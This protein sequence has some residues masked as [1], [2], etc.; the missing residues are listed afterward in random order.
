[1]N[2]YI[3]KEFKTFAWHLGAM[4]LVGVI[5]IVLKPEFLQEI[6]LSE[7]T[8]VVMGLLANR[9]TKMLNK[10]GQ[11]ELWLKSWVTNE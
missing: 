5:A 11:I 6:G 1:M 9:L 7:T 4:A 8:I 3:K 2:D 10:D